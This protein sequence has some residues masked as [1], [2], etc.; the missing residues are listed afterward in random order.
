MRER[1]Q[2]STATGRK[3]K[4]AIG[5]GVSMTYYNEIFKINLLTSHQKLLQ[6]SKHYIRVICLRFLGSISEASVMSQ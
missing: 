6:G 1:V 5:I 4:S 2:R 3:I